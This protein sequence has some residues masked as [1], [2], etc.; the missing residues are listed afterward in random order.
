MQE[1]L[2]ASQEAEACELAQAIAAAAEADLLEIARTL[3]GSTPATLFG[4]NESEIRDI[5][6]RIGAKAYEQL[7]ARKKTA[8]KGPA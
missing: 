2:T 1:A 8:T 3:L 7:L 4:A 6:L 5:V